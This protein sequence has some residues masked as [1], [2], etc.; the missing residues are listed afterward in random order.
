MVIW[1][2]TTAS[3]NFTGLAAKPGA[4]RYIS[5]GIASWATS[6]RTIVAAARAAMAS[7]AR[8]SASSSPSAAS[9]LA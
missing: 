7:A 6:V 3:L 8:T 4:I 1:V 2:S 5:H 9:F